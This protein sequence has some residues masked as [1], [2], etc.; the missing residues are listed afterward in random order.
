MKNWKQGFLGILAVIALTFALTAC[1]DGNGG[2]GVPQATVS[3]VNIYPMAAIVEKGGT[4]QFTATV[5]GT[6]SPSQNVSWTIV[7]T[8]KHSGTTINA[9]GLLTVSAS[10]ILETLT[11]RATST[12]DTSKRET[13]MVTVTTG[14]PAQYWWTIIWNLDGGEKGTGTYPDQI[15]KGTVLAQPAPH[16]TKADYAFSGWYMDPA[17][18]QVYN[19]ANTVTTDLTLYAKWVQ[20]PA[21]TNVSGSTLAVKLRWLKDNAQSN[22]GYTIEVTADEVINPHTFAYADKSDITV[23]LWGSGGEKVI[24]LAQNG[25]LFTVESGVILIL[26]NNITLQGRS[27]SPNSSTGNNNA[28]LV[29]VSDGVLIMNTGAK[30]SSNSS[31]YSSSGDTYG[32]GVYVASGGTFTMNGGEISGNRA[33]NGGGVFVWYGTFTMNGGEISG[34]TAYS[35]GGVY[36][37]GTFTIENGKISSNTATSSNGGGGGVYVGQGTFTMEGGEISGNSSS[38]SS[39]SSSGGGVY[40]ASGGNFTMNNGEISGNTSSALNSSGGGVFVRGAFTMNDGEISGNSAYIGGGV[41]MNGGTFTMNDGEISG[42]TSSATT[43]TSSN[44]GGVFVNSGTFRIV[45]GTVYGSDA[46]EGLKNTAI[47]GSALYVYN[48]TAQRGTLNGTVW[49]S[50]GNLT[51]TNTTIKVKNGELQ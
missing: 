5:N 17:L 30:I 37:G 23:T 51:T 25:S 9:S 34:N 46:V 43:V 48:G 14:Q 47:N 31:Y 26:D 45:T 24:S 16:P 39:N 11:I 18:T 38:Y 27:S 33:D 8:D 13:A 2:G 20:P 4:K 35:G 6:N 21:G 49:A 22:T 29:M 40:V 41:Y 15:E 19:F 36:S 10:E 7:Q 28:S 12:A 1:D 3:S 44:G 32:G 50:K 42:N